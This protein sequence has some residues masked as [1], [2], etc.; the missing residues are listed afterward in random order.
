MPKA[1]EDDAGA[2][3]SRLKS[4]EA[5]ALSSSEALQMHCWWVESVAIWGMVSAVAAGMR[6][7]D[8]SESDSLA[9]YTSPDESMAGTHRRQERALS[10]CVL[11]MPAPEYTGLR[12]KFQTLIGH[13]T[14]PTNEAHKYRELAQSRMRL[15]NAA[16]GGALFCMPHWGMARVQEQLGSLQWSS[17]SILRC[18]GPAEEDTYVGPTDLVN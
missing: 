9:V 4:G 15:H 1:A 5:C 10:L 12:T 6:Q 17:F 3:D 18:F 14:A 11:L 7:S 13:S 2:S 16:C 8:E